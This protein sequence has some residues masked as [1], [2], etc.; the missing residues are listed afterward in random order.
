MLGIKMFNEVIMV[1]KLVEKPR[2]K[3][4]IMEQNILQ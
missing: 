4:W 1:G 2:W 3:K